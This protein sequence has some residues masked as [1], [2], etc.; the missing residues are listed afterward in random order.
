VTNRRARS[1]ALD[2]GP[3]TKGLGEVP[4]HGCHFRCHRGGTRGHC[5][6]MSESPGP[7]QRGIKR[8]RASGLARNGPDFA[9][10]VDVGVETP[11]FP[12]NSLTFRLVRRL[13]G[14]VSCAARRAFGPP[15]RSPIPASQPPNHKHTGAYLLERKFG[16]K[17]YGI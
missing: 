16:A 6:Q 4:R 10:I 15:R 13:V 17:P 7:G 2:P 3:P 14:Q 9:S 8:R 12:A 1:R 5:R 11:C